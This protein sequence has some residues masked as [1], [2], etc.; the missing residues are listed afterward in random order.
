MS[1]SDVER[2]LV[3]AGR[4]AGEGEMG[5]PAA[6]KA[7]VEVGGQ[8]MLERVLGCLREAIGAPTVSVSAGD[9]AL[10]EATPNL[11]AWVAEGWLRHHPS[12]SS[13]AASVYD[14]LVREPGA[15][16][17]LVTTADHPLLTPAMIRHFLT[18]ARETGRD[19]AVAVVEAS[20]FRS[21][22]PHVRRT[23]VPLAQEPVTGANL[24]FFRTPRAAEAAR[25]WMRAEGM[26]KRPWR[27]VALFG[28]L[29]LAR[30]ATGRLTLEGAVDRV[31]SAM[32]LHVVAVRMPFAE[33]AIDVDSAADLEAAARVL[34]AR[35]TRE[36]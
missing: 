7:L 23:F 31:S 24:F 34:A 33:C 22:F 9:P 1:E 11:R 20:L 25:F 14:F 13:P 30:F 17:T 27:M 6:T 2:V 4:R 16:P 32:G 8:P 5:L 28:P 36:A 19:L 26:R 15:G 21:R 12:A 10:L 18:A 3:L 35:R 29:A